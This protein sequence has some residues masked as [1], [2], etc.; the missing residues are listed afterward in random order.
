MRFSRAAW[1]FPAIALANGVLAQPSPPAFRLGEAAAPISYHAQLAIDPKQAE[2]D[3][4]I[5][6]ELKFNRAVPLVWLNGTDLA[7]ESAE[8]QQGERRIAVNVVPGGE[9]FIGF[10][11]KGAPFAAGPATAVIRYRGKIEA[12]AT[13]GLF[14]QEEKGEWYVVSQFEAIYARRAF[15][16]FDEPGWKTP[17]RITIDAPAGNEVVSNT[18][19]ILASDL[20]G[21]AGWTRHD[22]ATTKP[23]PAYLVAMAVGPFDVVDGGTAG[24]NKT[25]LRYFAPKGRGAETRFAKEATPRLLEL[26]EQYF[27]IPYPFEKLDAVVIP[28][29]VGFGA[30]ENVGMITY[31]SHL[32]LATPREETVR[33]R[34]RYVSVGGHEIAHMWFGNLV[35]LAWW[36]DTWL[37][38]AFASWMAPKVVAGYRPEWDNGINLG[39]ART[40]A[41]GADRLASARRIRNSVEA[42][43]D[44][45]G[46]F[47][48]ITYEKGSAVLSMF[49]TWFTPQKFR[50]GVKL[51]LTRHEY[52]NATS[53]DFVRALGEASGQGAAALKTFNA[54]IEQPGMPLIDVS[55]DCGA[56]A[57]S[58]EVLQRRFRPVGS[59]APEAQWITP[60]CFRYPGASGLETRCEDITNGRHAIALPSSSACPE[61]V[62]G[63]AGGRS[64]YLPRY[65]ASLSRQLRAKLPGLPADEAV[66][67]MVD[68]GHLSGSG[69]M[70]R[71]EALAWADAGFGHPSPIVR[72]YAVELLHKQ[73]DGWLAPGEAR[74]KREIIAR[75][76][77]PLARE[78]GWLE[79]DGESDDIRALRPALLLYAA[80]TEEGSLLRSQARDL[81]L[82]WLRDREAVPASTTRQ[83]LETAARFADEAT[84]A[85]LEAAAVASEDRRERSHLF[86]ALGRAR[87]PKLRARALGLALQK[88]GETERVNG[89]DARELLVYALGDDT[90]RRAAMDFVRSNFPAIVA[91]LPKHSPAYLMVPMAELCTRDDREAFATFFKDR[92]ADF[93]GGPLNYRQSLESIDLCIAAL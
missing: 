90:N 44:V 76:V 34:Q 54:F 92:A 71:S 63:N 86:N 69:L 83:V 21:R 10:E 43:T 16:C 56:R 81:V 72:M 79:K 6:I 20:S 65:D 18:P 27:G 7:I 47:D 75:R 87:D 82:A 8:F 15:P 42:K 32:L 84:Y 3:G 13:E 60:V 68:A 23:L 17:W 41:I 66:T 35:T 40:N 85:R 78:L 4:Q 19:E 30:M 26:L 28:Q 91:K 62:L 88:N 37:N 25:A 2:F 50:E 58:I 48:S 29:T 22:F 67:L 73:R 61:W 49:E 33:F 45:N 77:Q 93:D 55:L 52:G 39:Y 14:R 70:S 51:F 57:A 1:L 53:E 12:V 5:R 11:A 64:H 9:D 80:E 89:R 38:E 74:A 59:T 31:A 36:D 24:A 46:A